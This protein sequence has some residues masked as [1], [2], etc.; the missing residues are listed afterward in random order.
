MTF[1]RIHPAVAVLAIACSGHVEHDGNQGDGGLFA[2]CE[3]IK[4]KYAFAFGKAVN[5]N[6]SAET[7][8]CTHPLKSALSC[9]CSTYVNG[10]NS[11]ALDELAALE[12]EWLAAGCVIPCPNGCPAPQAAI[13]EQDRAGGDAGTCSP[14][15]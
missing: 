11:E 2:Q 15:Y 10:A 9:G 3:S 7:P 14:V 1:P 5:C 4:V 13:C 12:A 8:M 6:A